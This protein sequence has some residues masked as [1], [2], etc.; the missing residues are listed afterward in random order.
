VTEIT[1]KTLWLGAAVAGLAAA[2]S[3]A[4][5]PALADEPAGRVT[6]SVAA[7]LGD[8]IADG[9]PVELGEGAAC[10]VLLDD[11]AV[12]ELCGTTSVVF[13]RDPDSGRRIVSLDRGSIRIVVEPRDFEERIEIHTPAAIAT[14]LGTI[15]YVSVDAKTGATTVTSA[16]SKVSVRSDEPDV[17]GAT[18]LKAGEQIV[19]EP[20]A[21]PPATP[22]RL[23]PQEISE[24]GGCQINFHT[25]AAD[26]DSQEMA[27]RAMDRL[28]AFDAAHAGALP[29][30]PPSEQPDGAPRD[31]PA[32]SLAGPSDVCLATDCDPDAPLVDGRKV[33]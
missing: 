1:P 31:D 9:E 22:R 15:V 2:L 24:L 17:R 14:L 8:A 11:D 18:V 3:S 23:D 32:G 30:P 7:A 16:Q 5:R 29:A 27:D 26:Q 19:V 4:P 28:T 6:A 10:S 25:A 33:P 21:A 20:G 12:V 13:E